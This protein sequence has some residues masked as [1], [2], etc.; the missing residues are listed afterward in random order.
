M[1]SDFFIGRKIAVKYFFLS[2]D[3]SVIYIRI[4]VRIV[5]IQWRVLLE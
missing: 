1:R 4:M 2:L 3:H 5:Q